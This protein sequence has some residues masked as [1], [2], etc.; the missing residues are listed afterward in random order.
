LARD[1]VYSAL[2][3][4]SCDFAVHHGT[5]T[6]PPHRSQRTAPRTDAGGTSRGQGL[7]QISASDLDAQV[8]P[9]T[10]PVHAGRRWAGASA[11]TSDPR[12]LPEARR[13]PWMTGPRQL[14]VKSALR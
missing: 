14:G 1:F 8:L 12:R 3:V 10:I 4:D 9:T 2:P 5:V 6:G 13:P 11:S 7:P